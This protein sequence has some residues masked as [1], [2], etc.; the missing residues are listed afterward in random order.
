VKGSIA[1][2]KNTQPYLQPMQRTYDGVLATQDVFGCGP[3]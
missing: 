3:S 1:F 2:A